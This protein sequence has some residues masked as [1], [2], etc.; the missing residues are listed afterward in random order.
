[1]YN[2]NYSFNR[3]HAVPEILFL[4]CSTTASTHS[5][6]VSTRLAKTTYIADI[7]GIT[8]VTDIN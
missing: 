7:T 6:E 3:L 5:S 8:K 4:N 2:L 1:M